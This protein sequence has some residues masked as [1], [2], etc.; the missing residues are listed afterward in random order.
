MEYKLSTAESWTKCTG[1]EVTGLAPGKYQVRLAATNSDFASAAADVTIATGAART[2]TL[3]VTAPA[4]DSAVYG[5]ASPP[6]SH[7]HFQQRQQRLR[8][9]RRGLSAY[10]RLYPEQ[11]GRRDG[12]AGPAGYELYHPARRRSG[13]G[14]LYGHHH[15][16]LSGR[17]NGRCHGLFHC[18]PGGSR[19]SQRRPAAC[20]PHHQQ[21]H[22]ERG[23]GEHQRR[24]G[25]IRHFYGRR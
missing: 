1:T 16:D 23:S 25:G 12:S 14:H 4:F 9:L 21:H 3:N 24:G 7:H 13:R 2:Y 19:C 22:A 8:H 20:Q 17:R 5:Y 11:D 15:R 10:Q 6:P 18:D